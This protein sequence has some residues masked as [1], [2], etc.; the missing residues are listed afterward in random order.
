[1]TDQQSLRILIAEDNPLEQ[2]TL[3]KM[4]ENLG[5]QVCAVSTGQQA[6]KEFM[7]AS[8]DL[9]LLDIMMPE[10]DGFCAA[11][12]IRARELATSDTTPLVALTSCSL[13]EIEARCH[14]ADMDG[15]LAKPVEK[16]KL[17]SMLKHLGLIQPESSPLLSE[18]VSYEHAHS[19][20]GQLP[21][22]DPQQILD[23]LANDLELLH[24]LV[25]LYLL[26]F[27]S[28][29]QELAEM[30]L[31]A[32]LDDIQTNAHGLK[33]MT[34]NL[35]GL[36]LAAIAAQIQQLCQQGVRPDPRSFA[37]ALRHEGQAFLQA[38]EG[39]DWAKLTAANSRIPS[40]TGDALHES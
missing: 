28:Q 23:N 3:K 2:A 26:S 30:L 37:A 15:Y 32:E 22:F 36:R 5:C 1:M 33:G 16:S 21:V 27:A 38:L 10:M 4:L 18:P 20:L 25:N 34:A 7:T 19:G 11:R 6:V 9:V 17:L 8:F 12:L 24:E 35:G 39:I 31:D 29:P 13:Q 14:A 40:N